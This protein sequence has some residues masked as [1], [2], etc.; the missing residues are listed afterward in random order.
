MLELDNMGYSQPAHARY[1]LT[2][3][4]R[5]R[6]LREHKTRLVSLDSA[7]SFVLEFESPQP[8]TIFRWEL[9]KGTLARAIG[10]DS[11]T[12]GLD[13]YRLASR[14]KGT[15]A[16]S[17]TYKDLGMQITDVALDPDSDLLVLL[18][19]PP[20]LANTV[21]LHLRSLRTGGS[22]STAAHSTISYHVEGVDLPECNLGIRINGDVL[23]S[24]V[25]WS[26]SSTLL[27]VWDWITGTQLLV[28]N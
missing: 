27:A 8:N 13:I 5:I 2:Y 9:S 16:K 25:R 28:S 6:S 21:R 15:K 17:W 1:D 22:H 3:A 20:S 19:R 4:S 7:K 14:N 24:E 26:S 10:H 23:S 12:R 18:E 11:T